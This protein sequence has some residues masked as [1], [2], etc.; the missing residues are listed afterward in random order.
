MDLYEVSY[1]GRVIDSMKSLVR[2]AREAGLAEQVIAAI[3]EMDRLLHLY[4]QFGQ[5]LRDLFVDSAQLWIGV[6]PPLVVDY[7]L[8]DES[9][10]VMVIFPPLP[11]TRSGL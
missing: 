4:P 5:P 9:R 8:D 6:V 2:R 7:V 3:R 11:L 10:K 1:S